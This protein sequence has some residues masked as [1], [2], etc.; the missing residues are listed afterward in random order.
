MTDASQPPPAFIV[1]RDA[2]APAALRGAVIAI[3]N[4]DGVHRGHRALIEAAQARASALGR[5]AAALTF[6]PHP[7]TVLRP[8]QP[9][10]R[11]S[12]EAT[13]LRLLAGTGLA[14]AFIVRF[15]RTL[16]HLPAEEF[17]QD[18]L[19]DRL[20]IAGAAIGFNFHF[21][22][23][24]EGTPQFLAAE[25]AR[26]GFAVDVLPQ[27]EDEGRPVSSQAVR[28]ALGGGRLVEA[29]ELLGFPW[30][31][32]GTVIHGDKRGR[33]LGYPTANIA[34]DPACGLR[35]GIYAVRVGVDG[36]RYGG[37]ASFGRRPMYQLDTPLLEI[38]LFDFAGDLYGRTIDVAFLAFIREEMK[39]NS[40]DD[41]VRRMDE[42]SRVAREA[43]ARQPD[44][45]PPL[46]VVAAG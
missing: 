40:V 15:D 33:E 17:V 36:V 25:G 18:I 11:L 31:M 45:Y 26:R 10:F 6:E 32:S 1:V 24:R 7:R 38:F 22:N 43:L 3:G 9:F 5:P 28:A 23:K 21:G 8:E 37:V 42:D 27:L 34:P 29:S 35:H 19:I 12:D 20:G 39:F 46:G 13:K 14:G 30:L 41:L 2:P 16:A 4:F 44:A